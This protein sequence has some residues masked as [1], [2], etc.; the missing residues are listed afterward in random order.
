M[1]YKYLIFGMLCIVGMY[2]IV[3]IYQIQMQQLCDN[4]RSYDCEGSMGIFFSNMIVFIGLVILC[5]ACFK[6]AF[7][8][9]ELFK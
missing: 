1:K 2:M 4:K 9:S 5:G 8:N 6:K 7:E 3:P